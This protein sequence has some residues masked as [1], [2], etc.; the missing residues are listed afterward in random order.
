MPAP[1]ARKQVLSIPYPPNP[2]SLCP[3]IPLSP[4]TPSS[5]PYVL[6]RWLTYVAL[7]TS[8]GCLVAHF[9]LRAE[10]TLG[11]A[12]SQRRLARWGVRSGAAL[13]LLALAR[14]WAQWL[15]LG[16]SEA[17]SFAELMRPMLLETF[18][19]VAL[20]AQFVLA[21]IVT[22]AFAAVPR[23]GAWSRAALATLLLSI[24]P[25]LSGHAVS[26]ARPV[27]GVIVDVIHVL[28]AGVWLGTLIVLVPI[29]IP[30]VRDDSARAGLKKLL[31][32]FSR[33]ALVSATL[34]L[35][36]GTYAAWVNIG[37]WHALWSTPYGNALLRKLLVVIVA[38][39][40]GAL[41]WRVSVPRLTLGG[42][43]RFATTGTAE[44][45]AAVLI[46]LLTAVL[47]GEPLPI[48]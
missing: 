13:A 25:A 35:V 34:L 20:M 37:S 27:L 19:G 43:Q 24:T 46:F 22:R 44:V 16:G 8:I 33:V 31:V 17:G 42:P 15:T 28:A 14:L 29:A 39:G 30:I 9:K 1:K 11:D 40:L 12:G 10:E 26:E 32:G 7:A 23:A 4:I 48:E 2:L 36:T 6:I 47:V 41:N 38:A 5:W 45:I 18:W 21:L 3:P